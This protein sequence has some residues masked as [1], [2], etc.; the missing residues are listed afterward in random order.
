MENPSIFTKSICEIMAKSSTFVLVMTHF[1]FFDYR[2]Y[3]TIIEDDLKFPLIYGE[4]K[5]VI[6]LQELYIQSVITFISLM[7]FIFYENAK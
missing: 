7:C 2:A 4:G 3:K 1:N 6:D 5:K